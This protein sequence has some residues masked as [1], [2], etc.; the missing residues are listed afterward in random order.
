MGYEWSVDFNLTAHI[1]TAGTQ[2]R[3]IYET[4]RFA[5]ACSNFAWLH[6][7]GAVQLRDSGTC[8]GAPFALRATAA[9]PASVDWAEP[10]L[11]SSATRRQI[12]ARRIGKKKSAGACRRRTRQALVVAADSVE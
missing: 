11:D 7:V 2:L 4:A 9:A 10:C 5:V 6:Q 3:V 8:N 1:S 12:I